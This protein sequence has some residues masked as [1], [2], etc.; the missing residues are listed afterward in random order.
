MSSASTLRTWALLGGVF[1]LTLPLVNPYLR[2]DGNG[3]YAYVRSAVID[4]DLNFE[5]EFRRGDPLFREIYFDEPGSLR[6]SM[7]SSTGLV[8]NQWAVGPSMLWL[9]FFLVAHAAVTVLNLFGAG[10]P[11]DGFSMPYRWFCAAGTA[12]YGWLS[13]LLMRG[14]ASRI[15]GVR[16]VVL[17]AL[18]LWWAS[19]LPVYMYFL[20]FHVHAL[21]AF[22][23]SLFLW[24]WLRRS[25]FPLTVPCWMIWGLLCGLMIDV[26]YLN[27]IVGLVAVVELV[28][29]AVHERRLSRRV[30]TT[31]VA[32]AIGLLVSLAPHV[33]AK[34]IVHGSPF[35]SGYSDEF[36]WTTPRLWQVGFSTEH[37][38]FVWTPVTLLAVVGLV[39]VSRRDARAATL[40][41]VF[42]L[43]Y[44]TIAS[45]Q[46][47]HGQSSFGNRFFVSLTAVFMLGGAAAAEW[48]RGSIRPLLPALVTLLVAWNIGFMFQWGANL[49]PSRGPVDFRTVARN[50]V[51]A[52]PQRVGRFLWRYLTD[53][54]RL[55]S[56]VE[57]QDEVERRG[58]ELRR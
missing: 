4:H 42:A 17:A 11:A 27:A 18:A 31:A 3:Y 49:V 35:S 50:Q 53:R 9:P 6:P 39:R 23:V 13:L 43:F 56:E 52:V 47:W 54:A 33:V 44:Y 15:A 32:F 45:Y 7:R 22:V 58:Y 51:E 28:T 41:V 14:P 12:C 30:V 5:N 20:P 34:W 48:A 2:G 46:N 40:L 16:A 19:S 37:G 38:L 10:V 8:I 26:Y 21:S 57:R 24:Y 25:S 1:V 29:Q 36:F 55:T